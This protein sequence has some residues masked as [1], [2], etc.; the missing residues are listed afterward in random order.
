[1]KKYNCILISIILLLCGCEKKDSYCA[2]VKRKTP[3]RISC[4]Y[5]L[6]P[7]LLNYHNLTRPSSISVTD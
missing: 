2:D 1:M 5:R 7:M 4:L 6:H 3:H